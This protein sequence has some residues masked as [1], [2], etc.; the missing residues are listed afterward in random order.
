MLK[1]TNKYRSEVFICANDKCPAA[2]Y[3]SEG[4]C[5]WR[6]CVD[7]P[8]DKTRKGRNNY[9]VDCADRFLYPNSKVKLIKEDGEEEDCY[10]TYC[11]EHFEKRRNDGDFKRWGC[12]IEE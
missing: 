7:C 3:D 4:I 10:D 11:L 12:T 6:V 5:M 2:I 8:Y 1:V 9:C